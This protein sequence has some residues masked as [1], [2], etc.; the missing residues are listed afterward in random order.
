MF[1]WWRHSRPG[2]RGREAGTRPRGV[3]RPAD[4]A[5]VVAVP[6]TEAEFFRDLEEDS[7]K[8]FVKLYRRQQP[9]V[10]LPSLWADHYAKVEAEA[11]VDVAAEVEGLGVT[12]HCGA[13]LASLG[14]LVSL[15]KVVTL[16]AHWQSGT[17]RA[18]DVVDPRALL[19]RLT[20]ADVPFVRRVVRAL[21]SDLHESML[22][23][24]RRHPIDA[25]WLEMFCDRLSGVLDDRPFWDVA[26]GSEPERYDEAEILE[27]NAA[28]LRSEMPDLLR[29]GSGFEF[30]DG[31]HPVARVIREIPDGYQGVL[32]LAVCHS[33]VPGEAIKRE[34]RGC[35]VMI[36]RRA[37]SLA[38]RL[39]LYRQVIRLLEGGRMDYV[40]ASLEL[41]SLSL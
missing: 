36:N 41:R 8:E 27:R 17:V 4:C 31:T 10:T 7:G 19:Q 26:S 29:D 6:V 38:F 22:A 12:V 25:A 35:L 15:R 30:A 34:R 40:T 2:S 24:S 9:D 3:T 33:V 18:R 5:L 20:E 39:P 32:D 28:C 23:R 21:P 16:V 37:A 13:T 14:A 1:P 11:I